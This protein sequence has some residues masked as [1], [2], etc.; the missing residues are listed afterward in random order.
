MDCRLERRDCVAGT[1]VIRRR[2]SASTVEEKRGEVGIFTNAGDV[3]DRSR[4]RGRLLVPLAEREMDALKVYSR[5]SQ[6]PDRSY[7]FV[8]PE[9]ELTAELPLARVP[10]RR[11][12]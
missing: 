7:R 4:V 11:H 5:V 9:P 8:A 2:Q 6:I 3:L 12:V 10:L 1:C